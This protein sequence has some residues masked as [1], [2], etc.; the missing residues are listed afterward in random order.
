[1]KNPCYPEFVTPDSLNNALINDNST[2]SYDISQLAVG[3]YQIVV[4]QNG[5]MLYKQKLVASR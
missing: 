3:M 1:M 5:H 2:Q 4:E